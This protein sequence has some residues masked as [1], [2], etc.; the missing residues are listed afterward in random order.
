LADNVRLPPSQRTD[1]GTL[2]LAGPLV[3][4]SPHVVVSRA[5]KTLPRL[6]LGLPDLVQVLISEPLV[7]QPIRTLV[8]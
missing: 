8:I 1:D 5:G 2:L 7:L 6:Q 3:Q 4:G